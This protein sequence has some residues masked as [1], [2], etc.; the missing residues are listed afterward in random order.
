MTLLIGYTINENAGRVMMFQNRQ[1]KIQG[2]ERTMIEQD[3]KD[4]AEEFSLPISEV[5]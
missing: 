4:I 3:M 2:I 1:P 5:D